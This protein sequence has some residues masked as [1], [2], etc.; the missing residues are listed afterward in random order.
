MKILTE[1]LKIQ[2]GTKSIIVWF[3]CWS[4][5]VSLAFSTWQLYQAWRAYS[6][7]T[8]N[9]PYYHSNQPAM[10]VGLIWSPLTVIVLLAM[11]VVWYHRDRREE[12]F[13][14]K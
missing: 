12:R 6:A 14:S 2:G 13:A 10:P 3:C 4:L 1:R 11:P 7:L 5:A 9:N 8:A